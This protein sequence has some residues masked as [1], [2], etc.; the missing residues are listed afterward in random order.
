MGIGTPG[1][2][3]ILKMLAPIIVDDL[4]LWYMIFN[5]ALSINQE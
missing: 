5:E 4:I 1:G 3:R 2:I